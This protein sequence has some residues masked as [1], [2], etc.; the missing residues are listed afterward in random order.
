MVK[1]VEEEAIKHRIWRFFCIFA[2]IN[3]YNSDMIH[4]IFYSWQSDLPEE[5]NKAYIGSC[6]HKALSK[7]K[8]SKNLITD[9]LSLLGKTHT[10]VLLEYLF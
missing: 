6:L 5:N 4:N 3:S 10:D 2:G 1:K 7:I 8:E 9:N